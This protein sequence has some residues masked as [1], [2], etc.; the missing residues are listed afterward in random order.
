MR[1]QPSRSEADIFVEIYDRI[2]R[3]EDPDAVRRAF[4][5][6]RVYIASSAKPRLTSAERKQ[7]ARDL[8]QSSAA[9]V[10]RRWG[11][12]VRQAYR[13]RSKARREL[14]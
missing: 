3:G 13:I 7:V 8:Q 4:A 6:E 5:G 12:S 14:P 2:M 1:D 10:A 11:I 9:E